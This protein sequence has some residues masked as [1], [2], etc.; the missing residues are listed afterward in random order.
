MSE[1]SFLIHLLLEHKLTKATKDLVKSRIQEIESRQGPQVI[2]YPA[3]VIGGAGG[4]VQAPSMQAKIEA[5]EHEKLTQPP[6]QPQGPTPNTNAA[7][8]ALQL[9]QQMIN[10]A[11][12]E[13][14][15]NFEKGRTSAR[16]F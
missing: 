1:L 3:Q 5:M 12:A 2:R 14:G 6:Q 13:S 11:L 9:R 15:G 7:A 16:K 4:V 8:Q 10:G